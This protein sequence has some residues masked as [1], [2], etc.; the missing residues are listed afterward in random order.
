MKKGVSQKNFGSCIV[1]IVCGN[2]DIYYINFIL[3][4]INIIGFWW[5]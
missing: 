1:C 5:K 4:E 2:Q 3:Y